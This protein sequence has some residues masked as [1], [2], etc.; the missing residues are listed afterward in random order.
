MKNT[1]AHDDNIFLIIVLQFVVN[2][3]SIFIIKSKYTSFWNKSVGIQ[4][5][6]KQA[7]HFDEHFNE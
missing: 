7:A 5:N 1:L 3:L 2:L 4:K 6:K